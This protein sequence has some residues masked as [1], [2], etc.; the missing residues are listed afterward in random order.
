MNRKERRAAKVKVPR[1]ALRDLVT[2]LCM[3]A[4][5]CIR[6][7]WP[8]KFAHSV[9]MSFAGQEVLR[10]YQYGAD[11]ASCVLVLGNGST[12]V[13]VGDPR[14][15]YDLLTKRSSLVELP[16]YEQW[17]SDTVFTGDPNG[18]HTVVRAQGE[19]TPAI[20]DLTFGHVTVAT[21]GAIQVPAT[22]AGFGPVE[23]PA[24]RMGDV[25]FTYA[26]TPEPPDMRTIT[27]DEWS[28][29][30]DDLY[31]LVGIALGY[32]NDERVFVAEMQRQMQ[33]IGR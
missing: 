5:W 14:A 2:S 25:W 32:R 33:L 7:R 19:R 30:I 13:C 27:T 12:T 3:A 6:T 1:P 23:W 15:G 18:L 31:T 4:P 24:I 28:G 22:F 20:A 11:M 8:P 10:R 17:L 29:L 16:T 9:E 26:P 21:K